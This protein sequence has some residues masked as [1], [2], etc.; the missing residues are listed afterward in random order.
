MIDRLLDYAPVV[1]V[2]IAWVWVCYEIGD[3]CVCGLPVNDCRC[4]G[5]DM[6]GKGSGRRPGEGFEA[7]WDA[8]F[9]KKEQIPAWG[10]GCKCPWATRMLGDG[11]DVCNPAAKDEKED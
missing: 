4:E 8:I 2:L 10:D 6:A 11:C 5:E 3:A 7:N 1:A 9:G